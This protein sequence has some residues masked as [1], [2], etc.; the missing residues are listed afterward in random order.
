MASEEY[1]D[2]IREAL[3]E[4]IR[5]VLIVDDEYPTWG[6]CLDP[7]QNDVGAIAV[8]ERN[9]FARL[10]EMIAGFHQRQPPLLVDI[11]DGTDVPTDAQTS[12]T[13]RLH[14]TD[15]LILDYEL[16]RSRPNDGTRAIEVLRV[17]MAN[18]HF[19]LVMICTKEDL[20]LVFDAVRWGLL[21]P[22]TEE[23]SDDERARAERLVAET[24]DRIEGFATALSG[25]VGAEQYFYARRYPR[26]WRNAAQGHQPYSAFAAVCPD[27]WSAGERKVVLGYLLSSV[28][29][30]H[31]EQM[32]ADD[33]E[34]SVSWSTDEKRW[35]RSNSAFV[36]F[37]S[38][39]DPTDLFTDLHDA[40]NDW[41]PQPFRLFLA[42]LRSAVEDYGIPATTPALG[43][44]DAL[45]YWYHRLLVADEPAQRWIVKQTVSHHAQELLACV[46]P[47]VEGFASRLLAA[48]L[49]NEDPEETCARHFQVNLKNR[50]TKKRAQLQHNMLV[51]SQEVIGWHLTLGH[52]F[53]IDNEYW[54]CL[55][56]ACDMV[57]TQMSQWRVDISG[58]ALPFLAVRLKEVN[59]GRDLRDVHTNRYVF[60]PR[61]DS[62][63]VFSFSEGVSTS[64]EWHVLYAVNRGQ[65][66]NQGFAFDVFRLETGTDGLRATA[67]GAEV[68]GQLRYEY[69]LNLTQ[70]LGAFLTRVGL[71]FVSA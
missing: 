8:P 60:L 70:K 58:E 30:R 36:G 9:Q 25:T 28:Q 2:C 5:S 54:L 42:K 48:E 41:C 13:S 38:K 57:P 43:R 1:Q 15:L 7:P 26:Y 56:A 17:L 52:I 14:Q 34:D 23:L 63:A 37:C 21:Q 16:D 44:P 64:P 20:D 10:K 69:A 68:V 65:F 18:T 59:A 24:D 3:I 4:P 47:Q 31:R 45:A 35:I 33:R 55:S 12:A 6:K 11:H 51:C 27:A 29:Y 61:D 71:E 53:R 62:V 39:S 67:Y 40:L 49:T 32:R 46:L 19:N 66:K 22:L 50:A